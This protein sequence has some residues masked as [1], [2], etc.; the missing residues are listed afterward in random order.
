[1]MI[2]TTILMM[3]IGTLTAYL[4]VR[5]GR[6]PYIWFAIGILL[7]IFGI[8]LLYI[9]PSLKEETAA[10]EN[11]LDKNKNTVIPAVCELLPAKEW[12]YIDE[13]GK[14]HGPVTMEVMKKLWDDDLITGA[15]FVW[16]EGMDK[17]KR[18][19]EVEDFDELQ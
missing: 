17:W 9:L 10:L 18:V 1:M 14:Q 3:F 12:F 6:D 19:R 5:R 13:D 16:S 4:A 15:T 11:T 7:G 2:L 8:A